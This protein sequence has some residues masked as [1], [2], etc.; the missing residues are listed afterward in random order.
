MPEG[1]GDHIDAR[2]YTRRTLLAS[3]RTFLAWW[4]TGLTSIAAGL[5]AAQLVPELA[6]S[7]AGWAYTT[8]GALLTI[9]G[10]TCILYGEH[11]RVIVSRAIR[12]GEFIEAGAPVTSLVT[13][14][15]ALVGIGLLI[16]ILATS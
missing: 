6:D 15:G 11:R 5:A 9:V 2:D 16:L 10:T 7:S 13:A 14:I 8:L 3:E 1:E 12:E 4:R